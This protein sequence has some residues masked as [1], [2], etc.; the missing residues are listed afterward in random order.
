MKGDD[1]ESGFDISL[2]N[3]APGPVLR[4]GKEVKELANVLVTDLP[5]VL[6]DK[7]I[8]AGAA[9]AG[10]LGRAPLT[11]LGVGD[12]QRVDETPLKMRREV[13]AI[14]WAIR[15]DDVF[16]S[17][18]RLAASFRTPTMSLA[19]QNFSDTSIQAVNSQITVEL[20]VR[21]LHYW[22]ELAV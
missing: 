6:G 12:D 22:R 2:P 11:C 9:C 13:V 18:N 5:F 10:L 3:P 8:D 4:A 15:D 20:K 7:V 17:K 16:F 14:V 19:K 21:L 1:A